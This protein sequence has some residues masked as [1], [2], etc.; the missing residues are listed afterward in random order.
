M[1]VIPGRSETEILNVNTLTSPLSFSLL[2]SRFIYEERMINHKIKLYFHGSGAVEFKSTR[3][4]TG[5]L[6]S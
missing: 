1:E 5:V 2:K 4:I 3:G 6:P